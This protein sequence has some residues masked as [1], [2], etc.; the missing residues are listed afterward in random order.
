MVSLKDI[1]K[2]C[3]V[4]IAT[5]SKALN[6]HSDI[7]QATKNHVRE[8]AD[9]LGYRPNAAAQAL[10]TNKTNN[11]GV[12]FVDEANSGLTHDYFNHVLDSFKRTAE[13]NGYDITFINSGNKRLN[14]MSYLS[15]AIYRGFDGIV[16]ACVDFSD[17]QVDELIK[18]D[19]P[20][21]TID[22]LFYNRTAI[23]S[24]NVNGMKELATY[25]YSQGHRKIAYIHGKEEGMESSVTKSR[26]SSF[27]KTLQDLGVEIPDEYLPAV[28]YRDTDAAY[29]AT[30][31][32][33]DLK[34]P[35]TCIFY[36][37]DFAAFGGM[38][39]IR[40]RGLKIPEDMSVVGYDGIELARKIIPLLTTMVQD[41][42]KIGSIAAT[43]L[44]DLINN[45][46]GTI[47]EQVVVKGEIENGESVAK[48]NEV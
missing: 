26:L 3:G 25:V 17:P 38:N 30:I 7:S 34:E 21:V 31:K 24:D 4:S 35:P 1:S 16:I 12:L 20:V 46:K 8:V 10:K 5:V 36:P 40:K 14:N 44:I 39:A 41:T 13:E 42:A 2:A 19:I 32:L 11:I 29:E 48:I 15:H 45:P 22:H 28:P 37:D 23:I 27:Y 33:L 43:K 47:V 6:D 9:K 18:S